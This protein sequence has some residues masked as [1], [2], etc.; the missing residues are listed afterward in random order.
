MNHNSL[1]DRYRN[2]RNRTSAPY[3][4][5]L[6]SPRIKMIVM[7]MIQIAQIVEHSFYANE[8]SNFAWSDWST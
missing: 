4:S 7:I 6:H 1:R 8:K 3:A 5:D 2:E